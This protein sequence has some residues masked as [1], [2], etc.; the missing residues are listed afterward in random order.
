MTFNRSRRPGGN[1]GTNSSGY[2][3][4]INPWDAGTSYRNNDALALA[5]NLLSNLLRNQQTAPPSLLEM[6]TR[7]RAYDCFGYDFEERVS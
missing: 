7:N 3:H 6:S 2:N 1:F 4:Q 5:N